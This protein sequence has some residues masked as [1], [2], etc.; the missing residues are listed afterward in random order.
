MVW[1]CVICGLFVAGQTV[2]Y[3][4]YQAQ[5]SE[6]REQTDALY[7]SVLGPDIGQSPFGRLQFEH[8]KLAAGRRIGLDPLSV[9]AAL[10]R[11]AV[12]SL[13]LEG[14]SIT[15]RTGRVRGFFGPAVDGFDGYVKALAA[16]GQFHFALERR[17]DVFGG[18]EFS[19]TVEPL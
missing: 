2:R 17:E 18:I 19:L 1:L 4:L 11:P 13:R 9:L 16:D 5:L 7:V 14:L 10:S 12:E 15:G 3:G 6:I 8:G